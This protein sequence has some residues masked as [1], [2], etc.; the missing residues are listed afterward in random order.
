MGIVA[1]YV[2]PATNVLVQIEHLAYRRPG[3]H[4]AVVALNWPALFI[5][6]A[7]I[8]D[9]LVHRAKRKNWSRRKQTL[10][11]AA[12]GLIGFLPVPIIFPIYPLVLAQLIGIPGLI[13]SLLLGLLGAYIGSWL[14]RGTG[15]PMYA[16]EG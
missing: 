6:G 16:L 4:L 8:I 10:I 2:P 14:G 5:V 13:V 1:L 7:I 9:S 15:E 11:V 12:S 3:A